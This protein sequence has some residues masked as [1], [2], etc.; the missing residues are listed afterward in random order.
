MY[1]HS[2]VLIRFDSGHTDVPLTF[3]RRVSYGL[4]YSYFLFGIRIRKEMHGTIF[5]SELSI[6]QNYID[7]DVIQHN[8]TMLSHVFHGIDSMI[9]IHVVFTCIA[10]DVLSNVYT[11]HG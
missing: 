3:I 2:T 11:C 7:G 8:I 5:S 1:G 4:Y 9:G 6:N 10:K